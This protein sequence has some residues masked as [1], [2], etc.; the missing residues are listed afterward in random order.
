MRKRKINAA[1]CSSLFMETENKTDSKTINVTSKSSNEFYSV[2][3]LVKLE[4]TDYCILSIDVINKE[5]ELEDSDF[6]LNRKT[7]SFDDFLSTVENPKKIEGYVCEKERTSEVPN[8]ID[9]DCVGCTYYDNGRWYRVKNVVD[10]TAVIEDLTFEQIFNVLPTQ[11]V[12]LDDILPLLHKKETDIESKSESVDISSSNSF[13]IQKQREEKSSEQTTANVEEA[14]IEL[15]FS[16]TDVA[17]DADKQT[18]SVEVIEKANFLID[19]EIP[20]KTVNERIA[21]NIKAVKLLKQLESEYRLATPEEQTVLNGF[22]SWGGLQDVFDES[23]HN[24]YYDELLKLYSPEEYISARESMLTAFYTPSAI[25]K[26]IYQMLDKCGFKGGRVLEP[27]MGNGR[28]FGCM[29]KEMQDNSNLYGIELDSAT[30][31]IAKQLYQKAHI[32]NKGFEKVNFGE[33]IFDL[34]ISNVPF[35]T[36][37]V[38]DSKYNRYNFSIHDYFICKMIDSVRPDGIVVAITSSHTMDKESSKARKYMAQRAEFLG[39]VRLPRNTFGKSHTDVLTDILVFQKRSEMIEDVSREEWIYS[40]EK[41]FENTEYNINEYF[42]THSECVLGEK[43]VV[44]SQF[45]N[46]VT[47]DGELVTEKLEEVLSRFS[48]NYQYFENSCDVNEAVP[49]PDELVDTPNFVFV[50]YEN[51]LYYKENG[52]I[53]PF[54]PKNDTADKRIR[55]LIP[56]RD[57]LIQIFDEQLK[58]CSDERL[59]DLQSK[60][61][62][63]YDSF[64]RKF[65]RITSRANSLA[66]RED[67]KYPLL[68]SL[69]ITNDEGEFERKADVFT[70]RTVKTYSTPSVDNEYDALA[71]SVSEKGCIDAEYMQRLTGI[72][73]E[74][75]LAKLCAEQKLYKIPFSDGYET[76]DS[77]LSGYVKDKLRL[78]KLASESDESFKLNVEALE[79]LQPKDIPYYEIFVQMGSTW[80]PTKYYELF[81]YELLDTP[82]FRRGKTKVVLF[83]DKYSITDKSYNDVKS[84]N[85]YGTSRKNAYEL[86][87]DC[88]NLVSTKVYDYIEVGDKT[89][90]VVNTEETQIAQTKQEAIKQKFNDWIWKDYERRSELERIYNDSMNNL[91]EREYDGSKLTFPGMNPKIEL[92]PHQKNAVSRIIQNGNTLLAHVV[93][94]GKT[95]T[96]IAAAMEKKRLGLS[97]KPLIVVPNHLVSQWAGEFTRLYPF[98]DVLITNKSDFTKQ[99]RQRFC[100]KIA[101]NNWDAVIMSHSQFTC[102]PLS[103]ERTIEE[104]NNQIYEINEL[105]S[106]VNSSSSDF[107]EK[108]FT[109]R[110]CEEFRKRLKTQLEKLLETPKDNTVTFEE[111]GVDSLYLDEAHLF[112]NLKVFTKLSNVAGLTNAA[113]KKASDLLMKVNYL[114]KI[115]DF[116]GTVFATGT[117]ISNAVCELYVMQK[118]LQNRDLEKHGVYSFDSWVSRFGE[119]EVKVEVK[120]EGTGYRTVTRLCKYHNVPELMTMF[121]MVADIKVADQLDLDVPK[122]KDHNIAVEPSETQKAIIESFA[123][124]ADAIRNGDVDRSV[125]NMLC[126]TNDGR[127]LAIDQRLYDPVL[128]DDKKSKLNRMIRTVYRIWKLYKESKATQLIFSDLGTP[129]KDSST[130]IFDVYAEC[131]NKLVSYGVPENEIAFIH[132]ANTD[133]KKIALFDKVNKGDVRILI[134]STEKLGAGTNV[135]KCLVTIHNLDCPWRPSDLEQRAGRIVRQGNSWKKVHIYSYVTKNTFD[136]YLYQT[137]LAKAEFIA[138]IMSSKNPSRDMSDIDT[139]CLNYAEIK[140]LS[141][142]NPAIKEKLE[143]EEKVARL[144]ALKSN[145]L[146]QRYDLEAAINIE[147]P[148]E[149]K[150]SKA[151]L[152]ALD[153]DIAMSADYPIDEEY[154][155][156]PM[157]VGSTEY[158]VSDKK[159]AIEHLAIAIESTRMVDNRKI[160]EYRGFELRCRYDIYKNIR[161]L[162]LYSSRS[163]Y[164]Y[165]I[166]LGDSAQGNYIR[167]N[168]GIDSLKES[169][170]EIENHIEEINKNLEEAKIQLELPFAQ[171]EE[172]RQ[173]V[174]RLSELNKKLACEGSSGIENIM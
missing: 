44:S 31:D 85:T 148:N 55:G 102:V 123:G 115:T 53:I 98:A 133:T 21:D 64:V 2:G 95:Y 154:K 151:K 153:T 48:F 129:K 94:A 146:S 161:V 28:F 124:R 18:K 135:Q 57:L 46:K 50:K 47:F 52:I 173:S 164:S 17:S 114:N 27:A 160:A 163:S 126:V 80:I 24:K 70:E 65:G 59:S 67:S 141:T 12:E 93:G 79:K 125:D 128:E 147:F 152:Y 14:P 86:F 76:A 149:I 26:A 37:S 7:M 97:N 155:F 110:Q 56:L 127:K 78:A 108:R 117:P 90:A 77:Y 104:I 150:A 33:N 84:A 145:Y 5:I 43:K 107:V 162:T 109:I 134:G 82:R 156:A 72:P 112:K 4:N 38:N 16:E 100:S 143:L 41:I 144:K 169:R 1:F 165:T 106:E 25:I 45:G 54:Q 130:K 60:L 15:L 159:A 166:E 83:K 137:V 51:K 103:E 34:A 10:K 121:R 6:F 49:V 91:V 99:N 8:N 11:R 131:K 22:T 42:D 132:D 87:E 20:Y 30:A 73:K 58:D 3:E 69:E 140:A 118:Y 81:L 172:Y 105:I 111:L 35:G 23:K 139:A 113:S 39:A 63:M 29:P 88:L 122:R 74:D 167:I 171:E 170:I 174:S 68:C 136:T 120:P 101:T 36:T 158:S 32:Q 92:M 66:F 75:I 157:T 40:Y 13:D 89:K 19:D 116:K 168:N 142:G 71:V 9:V 138:Q 119:T 96:M 61:S 62:Y